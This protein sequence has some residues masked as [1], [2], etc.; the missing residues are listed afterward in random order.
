MK[1]AC[2]TFATDILPKLRALIAKNLLDI[3][4]LNQQ[5]AAKRLFTSQSAIS[6]YYRSLR[7]S[8]TKLLQKDKDIE[9]EIE[10]LSQKLAKGLNKEEFVNELCNLCKLIRKKEIIVNQAPEKCDSA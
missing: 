5:E 7:G 10:K 6:Q 4:K 8:K 3:H 1:I 9:N 2:E